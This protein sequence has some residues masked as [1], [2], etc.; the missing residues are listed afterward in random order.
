MHNDL[1]EARK[2]VEKIRFSG[3]SLRPDENA[4]EYSN[5]S[6]DD[7]FSNNDLPL[8]EELTPE[9]YK[10]LQQTC[11]RLGITEGVV[12]GYV[13]SSPEIQAQC[14]S[15]E[16]TNCIIRLSSALIDLLKIEELSFIIGHELG[17]FLLSHGVVNLNYGTDSLEHFMQQ[18]A[19]EVSVDRVGFIAT[20]SIDIAI[21]SLMKTVSGLK[22]EYLRFDVSNYLSHLKK[23]SE[24][25]LNH[26]N[27]NTHP[28]IIFRC[29][30]LLWFSMKVKGFD[31]IAKV[32]PDV[33]DALDKRIMSDL[34]KYVDGPTRELIE[35]AKNNLA[36]WTFIDEIVQD[37]TFDKQEQERFKQKFGQEK[38]N[39][40]MNLLR[41]TSVPE[42]RNLVKQKLDKSRSQLKKYIPSSYG[43]ELERINKEF[44]S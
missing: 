26:S 31:D 28:S 17:H 3:D 27:S 19:Q 44:R 12:K 14:Y 38:L 5:Q 15:A 39:K 33:I 8:T 43:D 21:R 29:R 10:T 35:R 4:L 9:L 36:M 34:K 23:P 24:T 30:A 25:L 2:L 22:S 40:T 1:E 16:S 18:R 6:F 42:V 37:D 20:S 32:E 13:Y 11:E 7:F 41:S